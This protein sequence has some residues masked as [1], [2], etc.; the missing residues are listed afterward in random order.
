MSSLEPCD[1]MTI[2][3]MLINRLSNLESS[4][5][6]LTQH[7]KYQELI[8]LGTIDHHLFDWPIQVK[9]YPDIDEYDEHKSPSRSFYAVFIQDEYWDEYCIPPW[10]SDKLKS[11]IPDPEF[12]GINMES[13]RTFENELENGIGDEPVTCKK[14]GIDS[15]FRFIHEEI[16]DRALHQQLGS[17]KI[18]HILHSQDDAGIWMTSRTPFNIEQWMRIYQD[19][20][21]ILGRDF[22]PDQSANIYPIHKWIAELHEHIF[23]HRAD[24]MSRE[25]KMKAKTKLDKFFGRY[26]THED[27]LA[28]ISRHPAISTESIVDIFNSVYAW[29]N[30]RQFL[31][32]TLTEEELIN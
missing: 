27:F 32:A 14:M 30:H 19:A 20:C 22:K 31:K 9:R 1:T 23:R 4:V 6:K 10:Y 26:R 28:Y 18:D 8:K 25:N 12:V 15:P 29:V 7:H 24:L 3:D 21:R 5:D 13:L 2:F 17:N 16:M 11:P